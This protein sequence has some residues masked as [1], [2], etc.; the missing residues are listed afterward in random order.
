MLPCCV[1][2]DDTAVLGV[3]ATVKTNG[4]CCNWRPHLEDLSKPRLT[5][6]AIR[7]YTGSMKPGGGEAAPTKSPHRSSN[8]HANNPEPVPR[9]P[10]LAGVLSVKHSRALAH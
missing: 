1:A 8:S 2:G 7:Q 4:N 5:G 10:G 9:E 3:F 6:P